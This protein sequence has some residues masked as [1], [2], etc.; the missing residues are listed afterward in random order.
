MTTSGKR[1]LCAWRRLKKADAD[2]AILDALERTDVQ[3]LRTA[4][5]F[6]KDSPQSDR[7]YKALMGA[8]TRLTKEGKE[9]SRD[10]RMMILEAIAIQGSTRNAN[11]LT[12][13][14][15]DFD[16]KI[17]QKTA[18]VVGKWT[19]KAPGSRA[20]SLSPR[21]AA[22]I[23]GPEPVRIGPDVGGRSI[24][25]GHDAGR[26]SRHRRPLFEAGAEGQVLRRLT[27]HRVVPNFVLQGGSPNANEYSGAREFMRDEI[28]GNNRRG[29]VGLSTRGRNTAD[30]QFFINLIDNTRLNGDYTVFA[31]IPDE[32]LS[33]VD[34][35][36]EGD[37]IRA[38]NPTT[39]K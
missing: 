27:I 5:G 10:A 26:G 23:Q 6:L 31:R 30:A 33:V 37:V 22:G 36:Q 17:A 39:C 35:I 13:F 29:T 32:D 19:G 8:L 2:P 38:I 12:P 18:D 1:R 16:P 3:L 21:L 4:A 25:H 9:T 20:R 14:L 28:S 7:N 11:E 24:P 15:K 34:R